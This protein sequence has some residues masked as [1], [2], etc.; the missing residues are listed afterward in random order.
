MKRLAMGVWMALLLAAGSA[1]AE[2]EPAGE[3]QGHGGDSLTLWKVAN[4]VL[5][6]GGLGYLIH[7]KGG[8]FFG[9]RTRQIRQGIE[10]A[11][12]LKAE[13]EARVAEIDRRLAS[14]EAEVEDLR[15]N[16]CQETAAE[17]ERVR[18]RIRQDVVKVHSQAEQEAAS[19]AQAAR[20]ELRRYAAELA[21]R[22]AEQRVRAALSPEVEDRLVA[23]A[24]REL[25]RVPEQRPD[26][27]RPA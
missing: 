17:G 2:P 14:L 21:V 16:A 8:A 10:D 18:A 11:A 6:A 26:A 19:A 13:A 27:G 24:I 25:G 12:R 5:L 15:A 1:A 3:D 22:L 7:K 4:F 20:R 9:A 23:S